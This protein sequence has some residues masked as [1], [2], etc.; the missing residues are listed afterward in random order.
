MRARRR[1]DLDAGLAIGEL[2][3][4]HLTP[5]E[6][7]ALA[8]AVHEQRVGGAGEDAGLTHSRGWC[9]C[10]QARPGDE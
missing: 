1:T 5:V 4:F 6:T 8:D 2:A 9:V 10:L 3:K 7:E